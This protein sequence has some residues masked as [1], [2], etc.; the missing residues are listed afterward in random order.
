[1]TIQDLVTIGQAKQ[2]SLQMVVEHFWVPPTFLST[3]SFT[4]TS[5]A[6]RSCKCSHSLSR[7]Y[8]C[9]SVDVHWNFSNRFEGNCL[10]R[11]WLKFGRAIWCPYL[12][13]GEGL[14]KMKFIQPQVGSEI[15]H[16]RS[17]REEINPNFA[18]PSKRRNNGRSKHGRGHTVSE[19]ARRCRGFF[20]VPSCCCCSFF[21]SERAHYKFHIVW[22]EICEIQLPW[23]HTKDV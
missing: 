11:T 6:T 14:E 21:A 17:K 8:R 7:S 12:R 18:M 16:R 5:V 3:G 10:S 9:L 1:M 19:K 15:L 13:R 2:I 20:M 23:R 4:S 22:R